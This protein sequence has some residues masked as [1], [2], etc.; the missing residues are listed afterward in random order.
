M[1]ATSIENAAAGIY[2]Y[3]PETDSVDEDVEIELQQFTLDSKYDLHK[4][5]SNVVGASEIETSVA[6]IFDVPTAGTTPQKV[7]VRVADDLQG[8]ALP[9]LRGAGIIDDQTFFFVRYVSNKR[10]TH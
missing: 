7:F 3:S 1:F 10:F 9:Q 6:H 2:M 4:Y 8:S 5:K